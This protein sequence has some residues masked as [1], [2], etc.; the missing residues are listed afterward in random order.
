M[1]TTPPGAPPPIRHLSETRCYARDCDQLAEIGEAYCWQHVGA[2]DWVE[3]L[4]RGERATAEVEQVKLT[5]GMRAQITAGRF[6]GEPG[7]LI[8]AGSQWVTVDLGVAIDG[9]NGVVTVPVSAVRVF[10]Q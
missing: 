7:R 2:D 5:P 6:A 3:R 1:T 10:E 4:R 9:G 8:A